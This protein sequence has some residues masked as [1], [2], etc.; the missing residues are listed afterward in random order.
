MSEDRTP[1]ALPDGLPRTMPGWS[2]HVAFAALAAPL[3]LSAAPPGLWTLVSV[4]LAAVTVVVPRWRTAWVL[5][6]VL[7]FS[8]LGEPTGTAA[9]RLCL[10][11][12][13]VHALHV[14]AAWM[15]AVP[16]R[17]R[18]Q[19]AVLLPGLGRFAAIQVPVQATA[20][21]VGVI[22]PGTGAPGLAI[23]AGVAVLALVALLG[24]TVLRRSRR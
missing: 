3:A 4:A 2:L 24:V 11:I 15:L 23:A 9:L 17:A 12:A 22:R 16:P 19:A 13:G 7:A 6:A 14:L 8:I 5:I 10:L 18:V 20:L 21:L 1:R